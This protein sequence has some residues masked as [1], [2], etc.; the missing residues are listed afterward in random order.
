M[1]YK[2]WDRDTTTKSLFVVISF[3]VFWKSFWAIKT[4][5]AIRPAKACLW[6]YRL[7]CFGRAFGL[8]KL[9]P[10]YDHKKPV[11]GHIVCRALEELLGQKTGT[12]T[13]PQKLCLRSYR[14]FCFGDENNM[15]VNGH[16]VL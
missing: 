13:R 5:T 1:G 14:L 3:V 9:G 11:C 8:Q 12:A 15:D 2:N 4:G 6:S 16:Y 10:R 7:L